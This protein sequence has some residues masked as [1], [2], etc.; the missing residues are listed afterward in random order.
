MKQ[1]ILEIVEEEI[2]EDFPRVEDYL[3]FPLIK[4][5]KRKGED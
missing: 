1:I 5:S 2:I 3:K 4:K